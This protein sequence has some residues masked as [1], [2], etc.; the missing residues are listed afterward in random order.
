MPLSL[1]YLHVSLGIRDGSVVD[2]LTRQD[3]RQ[4]GRGAF[5]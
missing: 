5:E 2:T 1:K 4:R 3:E